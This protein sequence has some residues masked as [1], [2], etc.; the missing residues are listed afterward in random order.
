MRKLV[1]FG[2][3]GM[4]VISISN[5]GLSCYSTHSIFYALTKGAPNFAEVLPQ[6]L[7]PGGPTWGCYPT[8]AVCGLN[9][10]KTSWAC[11]AYCLVF[12]VPTMY[13]C[14]AGCQ[15]ICV[16]RSGSY[17]T[18]RNIR[19]IGCACDVQPPECPAP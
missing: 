9:C 12:G 10:S 11:L 5:A 7:D 16:T 3:L 13:Y 14:E 19:S 1:T 2:M 15:Y 18:C 6:A 8:G 17:L 4:L